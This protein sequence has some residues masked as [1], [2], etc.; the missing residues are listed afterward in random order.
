MVSVV[1]IFSLLHLACLPFRLIIRINRQFH[2]KTL[3]A[4]TSSTIVSHTVNACLVGLCW[5]QNSRIWALVDSDAS[6]FS[7]REGLCL[8]CLWMSSSF[9]FC[10]A[11]QSSTNINHEA[12]GNAQLTSFRTCS[13]RLYLPS[14]WS[15][16]A[17]VWLQNWRP[18]SSCHH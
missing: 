18:K 12:S 2:L 16:E 10:F 14:I 7:G 3:T 6:L 11:K 4:Q 13:A 1:Y 8:P 5:W 15:V 9:C 17:R